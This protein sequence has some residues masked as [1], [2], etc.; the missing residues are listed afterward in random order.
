MTRMMK[1]ADDEQDVRKVMASE[2]PDSLDALKC[3]A[4]IHRD[5]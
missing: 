4:E 2:A 5:N 3:F 1:I